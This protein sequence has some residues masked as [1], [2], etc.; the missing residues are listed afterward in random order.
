MWEE[1]KNLAR[2][3]GGINVPALAGVGFGASVTECMI[4]S[5]EDIHHLLMLWFV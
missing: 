3:A 5:S 2:A 1:Y 4:V